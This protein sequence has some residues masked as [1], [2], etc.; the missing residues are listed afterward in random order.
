MDTSLAAPEVPDIVA[1]RRG[2]H[3]AFALLVRNHQRIVAGLCQTLGLRQADADD[4]SADA[5]AAIFKALPGFRGD[6]ALS[7]WVYRIAFRSILKSRRRLLRHARH[8][9]LIA[10][11]DVAQP[12]ARSADERA[13]ELWLIVA[14]L[15]P[16]QAMALELFYRR[17]WPVARIA[18][19]MGVPENQVKTLLFRGRQKIKVEL[20]RK[21]FGP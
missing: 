7:T 5:F 14:G 12:S 16:K 4:A 15:K 9:P 18:D 1:L 11:R 20:L 10:A 19:S 3:A 2:D 21:G 6:A 13:E 17:D 8:L